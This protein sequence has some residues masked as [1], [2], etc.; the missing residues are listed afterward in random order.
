M[1]TNRSKTTFATFG[2]FVVIL[3][4]K[5][6][7]ADTLALR[8]LRVKKTLCIDIGRGTDRWSGTKICSESKN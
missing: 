2:Q 4:V 8:A 1:K 3:K 5:K 7:Y 6:M